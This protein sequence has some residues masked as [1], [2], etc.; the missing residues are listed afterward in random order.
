MAGTVEAI[1]LYREYVSRGDEAASLAP[2]LQIHGIVTK[3]GPDPYALPSIELAESRGAHSRVL[4][5]LPLQS[6]LKLRHV[7]RGDDVVVEG[8]PLV[9][10]AGDLDYVVTKRCKILIINGKPQK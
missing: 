4:C 1:D 9:Y 7:H 2:R 8:N 5:V 10:A 3:V 6:Y